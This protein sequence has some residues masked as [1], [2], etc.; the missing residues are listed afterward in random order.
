MWNGMF[1]QLQS[2]VLTLIDDLWHILKH[3]F[4]QLRLITDWL[5]KQVETRHYQSSAPL[6]VLKMPAFPL[7]G[8]WQHHSLY[9]LPYKLIFSDILS[10]WWDTYSFVISEWKSKEKPKLLMIYQTQEFYF[11][12]SPSVLKSFMMS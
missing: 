4:S 6:L 9:F 8:N 7:D 1:A 3:M 11:S 10:Q 2:N 5:T 12:C